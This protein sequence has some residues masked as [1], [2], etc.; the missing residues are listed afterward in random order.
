M[1]V[2]GF[3]ED[4]DGEIVPHTPYNLIRLSL[5]EGIRFDRII[6]M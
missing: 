1:S 6:P 5:A 2:K 4:W 3:F